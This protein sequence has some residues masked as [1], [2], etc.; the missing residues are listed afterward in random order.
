MNTY[1]ITSIFR[2]IIFVLMKLGLFCVCCFEE[3]SS[4][5][6]FILKV[7]YH[8]PKAFSLIHKEPIYM[9]VFILTKQEPPLTV[10]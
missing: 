4:L 2:N 8:K 5:A 6:H 10:N 1:H 9:Q 3:R 7:F